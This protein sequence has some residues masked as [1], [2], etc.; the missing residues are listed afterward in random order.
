MNVVDWSALQ[1]TSQDLEAIV[2]QLSGIVH[3]R[4]LRQRIVRAILDTFPWDGRTDLVPVFD[5]SKSYQVG[6]KVA[7]PHKEKTHSL[8]VQSWVVGEVISV[9]TGK[10]PFQGQ[11]DIVSIRVGKDLQSYAANVRD[12][13][14]LPIAFP[15]KE[16]VDWDALVEEIERKST[17]ILD[18]RIEEL[19]RNEQLAKWQNDV[20]PTRLLP[21]LTDSAKSAI[22]AFFASPTDARNPDYRTDLEI[23][24]VLRERDEGW[25]DLDD[26]L[27][28]FAINYYLDGSESYTHIGNGNWIAS[29]SQGVDTGANRPIRRRPDVPMIPSRI[30]PL[31]QRFLEGAPE[32]PDQVAGTEELLA[33]VGE[34]EDGIESPEMSLEQW[35]QKTSRGPLDLPKLTFQHLVEGFIPLTKRLNAFF[36]P[37][38]EPVLVHIKIVDDSDVLPFWVDRMQGVVKAHDPRAFF[39]KMQEREH[40]ILPG[41][42]LRIERMGRYEY[43]IAPIPTN[44]HQVSCKI[45]RWSEDG[46]LDF[47]IEQITVNYHCDR[48][49]FKA[50]YRHW[51]KPALFKEAEQVNA[52]IFDLVYETLRDW[53]QEFQEDSASYLDLFNAVFLKRQCSPA[54]VAALLYSYQCFVR[55]G[56]GWKLNPDPQSIRTKQ[57]ARRTRPERRAQPLR[58][59]R[60]KAKP[61]QQIPAPTV[62]Q[63]PVV[64]TPPTDSEFWTAIRQR[65]GHEFATLAQQRKFR[66]ESVDDKKV[67]IRVYSTN[68]T[69]EIPRKELEEAWN[70]LKTRGEL[71]RTEIHDEISEANPAYIAAILASFENVIYESEPTIRLFYKQVA[72]QPTNETVEP[73]PERTRAEQYIAPG[74][75]PLGPLFE[76]GVPAQTRKED[77]FDLDEMYA[78][79]LVVARGV[80]TR[81]DL[82]IGLQKSALET[83]VAGLEKTAIGDSID[84]LENRLITRFGD[85][86]KIQR[87]E[88]VTEIVFSIES[89]LFKTATKFLTDG[90]L[91]I[92][93]SIFKLARKQQIEFARGFADAAGYV[94]RAQY[95]MDGRIFIFFQIRQTDWAIPTQICRLFQLNLGIPVSFIIWGHPNIR[96][97]QANASSGSWAKEHQLKVFC[98]AFNEVGFFLPYKKQAFAELVSINLEMGK[99]LPSLCNPLKKRN[100]E[101]KPEHPEE[102]SWKLPPQIRDR[103]FNS[104]WQV[105]LKMGCPF[106]QNAPTQGNLW[107]RK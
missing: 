2:A 43:R 42:H 8:T 64:P 19:V 87:S 36:P 107:H 5:S 11:F 63:L 40:P 55:D 103:H 51:D 79:G 97:P 104:W 7:L 24:N 50:E 77:S 30:K 1:I 3:I 39:Q 29:A 46:Q 65:Q 99:S 62:A 25:R 4:K 26:A 44:S 61:E 16:D 80:F 102:D 12:G 14:E 17:P 72:Q 82:R 86:V 71:A 23:A 78:L 83:D 49:L 101:M 94:R 73:A 88:N 96:D 58:P 70:E 66:I 34:E 20:L 91:K 15:P 9:E 69:R 27:A 54:S 35:D 41:V 32:T 56:D 38:A 48:T 22:T 67:V 52:S 76:E 10:N 60:R 92:P 100:P 59:S 6:Q 53:K 93:D 105:C 13:H 37:S 75:V 57:Y 45:A 98:D 89:E 21:V 68:N 81:Q 106:A 84:L 33:Q 18:Q 28:R 85:G 47:T 90:F 95:Y 31:N 74:I